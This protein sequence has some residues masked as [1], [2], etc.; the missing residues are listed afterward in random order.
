MVT[1]SDKIMA[2]CYPIKNDGLRKNKNILFATGRVR[3]LF[4]VMAF[5]NYIIIIIFYFS[6]FLL[7]Y[8]TRYYGVYS[9]RKEFTQCAYSGNVVSRI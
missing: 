5:D 7:A 6:E 3:S 9:H 2:K 4:L 1:F 8:W